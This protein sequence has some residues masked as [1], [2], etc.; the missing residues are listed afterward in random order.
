VRTSDSGLD[1]GWPDYEGTQ[2]LLGTSPAGI[3]MPVAQ[4]GH[5]S[6]PYQGNSIIGGFVYRG[7]IEPLQGLYIFADFISDNVWSAPIGRLRLGATAST[8][9]FT[10]RNASF[11]P[12][13]GSL[14]GVT[15][16]GE[17][18]DGNLFIVTIGGDVFVIEPA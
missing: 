2:Q 9:V 1:M 10:N 3:T 7:P 6:G 4:Y 16:F 11:A 15:G 13:A 8:N 5:G 12:D 14:S 18:Q 17:D